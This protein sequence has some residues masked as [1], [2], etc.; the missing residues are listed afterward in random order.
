MVAGAYAMGL[1]R[2]FWIMALGCCWQWR[3]C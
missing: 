3:H 2:A 1:A